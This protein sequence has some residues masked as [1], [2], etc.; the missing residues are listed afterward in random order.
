MV[1]DFTGGRGHRLR[2][3]GAGRKAK[4]LTGQ[5]FGR[6]TVIEKGPSGQGG[7]FTWQCVCDCGARRLVSG[8]RLRLGRSR[9]CGCLARELSRDGMIDLNCRRKSS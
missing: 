6:W 2:R 9:S 5:R 4:D 7:H 1:M 3:P 8:D